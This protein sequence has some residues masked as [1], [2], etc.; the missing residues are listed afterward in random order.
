MKDSDADFNI[1]VAVGA[2]QCMERAGV[3][4]AMNGKVLSAGSVTRDMDTGKFVLKQ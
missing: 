3:Y 1:G 4:V 2:V